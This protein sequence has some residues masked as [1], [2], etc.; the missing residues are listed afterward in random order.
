MTVSS[1]SSPVTRMLEPPERSGQPTARAPG[2]APSGFA[3]TL[4]QVQRPRREEVTEVQVRAGDTLSGIVARHLKAVAPQLSPS[5]TQLYQLAVEVARENAIANPNL[6]LAGQVID[7]SRLDAGPQALMQ[8]PQANP[9][10]SA[11][12]GMRPP[13]PAA[14]GARPLAGPTLEGQQRPVENIRPSM[15]AGMSAASAFLVRHAGAAQRIEASSG[16]PATYMLSQAALETGWGQREIK[17]ADGR[18]SFNLFGI[19]AG[20]NWRGPSV[21]VWTTEHINGSTQR[22]IGE[23]RAYSSYEESFADYARLIGQE[24]RYAKVMQN[25]GD[26]M[27]FAS[28]L[29]RAGYA[30][31]PRYA[32]ALA[33][34]IDTTHRLQGTVPQ[35][36]AALN[37]AGQAPISVQDAQAAVPPTAQTLQLRWGAI[38]P[39]AGSAQA[40]VAERPQPAPA[41]AASKNAPR[42][43]VVGDSIAL[44]IGIS[45]L[46]QRGLRPEFSNNGNSLL[47]NSPGL[48]VQATGGHNSQQI[49]SKIRENQEIKS[50]DL[51]ILSVSTNDLAS[52]SA[53]RQQ[54]SQ[55]VTQNLR[56]IRGSLE[57]KEFLWVLPYDHRAR[58]LVMQ[59]AQ[60]N[61]DRVL[62][63]A[64]FQTSDRYHPKDYIGIT[65]RLQPVINMAAEFTP[66]KKPT[67]LA[68]VTDAVQPAWTSAQQALQ[69]RGV[70]G[71][72]VLGRAPLDTLVR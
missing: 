38:A 11:V 8:S 28:A 14:D 25:L 37:V 31:G 36:Q 41:P 20:G 43:A 56:D 17:S 39:M 61:G 72:L 67:E 71:G 15:S 21:K 18:N 54:A 55:R 44:G 49:L 9:G 50:A 19:R 59:V 47:H 4:A 65:K 24:P 6:I 30:T 7:L 26:P 23:F 53:N 3:Q 13:P 2:A 68:A 45:V 27:A 1:T 52:L 29:H 10:G 32:S 57:A 12:A 46:R 62:D 33:S 63:L 64:E 22:M 16:I 60:Q 42:V 34:M 70:A 5:P 51:A 58:D 35:V 66:A 48:T 40:A 69:S